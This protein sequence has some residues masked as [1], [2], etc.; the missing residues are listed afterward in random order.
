M[1]SNNKNVTIATKT[2]KNI[3]DKVTAK[4][5]ILRLRVDANI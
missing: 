3:V 5:E 4:Q 2:E 1:V